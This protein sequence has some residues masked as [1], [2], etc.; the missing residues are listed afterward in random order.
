MQCSNSFIAAASHKASLFLLHTSESPRSMFPQLPLPRLRKLSKLLTVSLRLGESLNVIVTNF[1][2]IFFAYLSVC[3]LVIRVCVLRHG[4]ILGVL[5]LVPGDVESTPVFLERR[6]RCLR[7]ELS[8]LPTHYGFA[9][10]SMHIS[11]RKSILSS[12][13]LVVLSVAEFAVHFFQ[14]A[15][16]LVKECSRVVAALK[17]KHS[18]QFRIVSLHLTVTTVMLPR[19]QMSRVLHTSTARFGN[20]HNS[21]ASP[22]VRL[23]GKRH[24]ACIVVNDELTVCRSHTVRT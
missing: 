15:A 14:S 1:Q 18:F 12:S 3:F 19:A 16:M 9:T 6:H 2:F 10:A 8:A 22:R 13:C 11:R 7:N 20:C 17:T 24:I 21:P 5:S 4:K 23:N